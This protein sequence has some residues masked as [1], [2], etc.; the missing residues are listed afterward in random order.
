ML[1][2]FIFST[3]ILPA[4]QIKY[5]RKIN[6][7]RKN[8]NFKKSILLLQIFLCLKCLGRELVSPFYRR[9][10]QIF[11]IKHFFL[12]ALWKKFVYIHFE[13]VRLQEK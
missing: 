4:N 1:R 3:P 9:E 5:D 10:I 2:I 7:S 11:F 8:Q 12:S 13:G 6:N